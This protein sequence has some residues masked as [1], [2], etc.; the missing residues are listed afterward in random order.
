MSSGL[1]INSFKQ[2]KEYRDRYLANLALEVQNDNYNLQAN[3]VFKQT[4]QVSRPPDMRTTTE[5]L[6]DLEKLKVELRSKFGTISDQAGEVVD[7]L[8]PDEI[9]FASQQAD[10]IVAD[11]KPKFAKGVP[12]Y[13]LLGYIRQLRRKFMQTSGVSFSMQESTAE[14]LLNAVKRGVEILG[15]NP[16]A[17]APV[18]VQPGMPSIQPSVPGMPG[19]SADEE[20]RMQEEAEQQEASS[21]EKRRRAKQI[22]DEALEWLTTNAANR[23]FDELSKGVQEEIRRLQATEFAKSPTGPEVTPGVLAKFKK[24]PAIQQLASNWIPSLDELNNYPASSPI[25]RM[26]NE[27]PAESPSIAFE[28]LKM[29]A[30]SQP[31]E[32]KDN[33]QSGWEKKRKLDTLMRALRPGFASAAAPGGEE[34]VMEEEILAPGAQ[35][36]SAPQM[37]GKGFRRGLILAPPSR[38]PRKTIMG[39]GLKSTPYS[40]KKRVIKIDESKGISTKPTFVRFGKYVINTNKLGAG[41]M[42]IRT[43]NGASIKKYPV[44]QLSMKLSK[45]INRIVGG[46]L[47]DTY[48][49]QELE[50][51]DN[52]YLYNLAMDSNIND[53]LNIPTPKRSKDSEEMNRFEILKGQIVAG[54]DSRELVKEFKQLLVKFSNDGRIKKAEAREILLDLASMGY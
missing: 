38:M 13:A 35:P 21:R 7:A 19:M 48:D 27:Y 3:Q 29:W 24:D 5:K 47:P 46:R 18:I 28:F 43:I 25:S 15:A 14:Q 37:E 2:A 1:P 49:I 54:N 32:V 50:E 52:A 11:L 6:A 31:Q 20:R 30:K 53:R 42:D 17:F 51:D 36:T 12:S 16:G 45:I 8:T 40:K 39:K 33:F 44:K 41:L 26:S 10:Q 4:G 22:A 34:I 23:R 9:V